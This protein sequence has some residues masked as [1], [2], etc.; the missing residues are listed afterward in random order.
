MNNPPRLDEQALP[1]LEALSRFWQF[2]RKKLATELQ[3]HLADAR[4]QLDT[5]F[6]VNQQ[7]T[8]QC[9][10]QNDEIHS[11]KSRNDSLA[12]QLQVATANMASTAEALEQDKS[13]LQ[14]A[15]LALEQA[16]NYTKDLE[17]RQAQALAQIAELAESLA[18]QKQQLVD[19]ERRIAELQHALSDV[20]QQL[21]E[22]RNVKQ[23]LSDQCSGQAAQIRTLESR[24]EALTVQL[25]AEQAT[26]AELKERKAQALAQI[27][28]LEMLLEDHR[29]QLRSKEQ[30]VNLLERLTEQ[31]KASHQ[32]LEDNYADINKRHLTL[33]EKFFLVS[34]VL[35]QQPPTNETLARFAELIN[36]DYMEFASRDSSLA[37]EAQAV[38]EM[39]AILAEMQR[40]N[41]FPSIAGKTILSI[42][43]G[44]SSGKS[45]LINSFIRNPSVQLATGIN[46]VTVVPS[47]VVCSEETRIKGYSHNGGAIDLEPSLY[48][49][50]CH[51]YVQAFGFDLRRI[52]PFISVK[53]PMDPELFGNLCIIDTPGYNPGTSGGAAAAD[54]GTAAALVN[55]ASALVWVIGLDPAGTI[56]LSDIE[57]IESTPFRGESLYIVLNKADVKSQEDILKIMEQVADDL[58][59][60]GIEYAGMCAY[61]S[62]RKKDYP[63]SGLTLDQFLRSINRKVDVVGKVSSRLDAVFDAYKQAINADIAQLE[64]RKGEFNAFKLDALEIGGTELFDRIDQAFPLSEQMFDSSVLE[65]LADECERLRRTLKLAAQKA[66]A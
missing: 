35:A 41:N 23:Q 16:K 42:A 28:E 20:R 27:T 39:Q 7:L 38:L 8:T 51:E 36:H 4:R 65:R 26:A 18:E 66:L 11:L 53:V 54:R 12:D 17:E 21:E 19:K 61:S 47:Y 57:F 60:A 31:L 49:S 9:A 33:T 56:D 58:S 1:T 14:K 44:F 48:A 40:L 62:T 55:Q 6:D 37:G 2:K 59:F 46:P 25:Q 64:G 29:S 15:M 52:L 32:K 45:A 10:G 34:K 3:G 63:S 13:K 22:L 50:M 30:N 24:N 5:L 43:G